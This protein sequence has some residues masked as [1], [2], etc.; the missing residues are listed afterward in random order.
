MPRQRESGRKCALTQ[1]HPQLLL[2]PSPEL[3]GPDSQEQ[4]RE[5]REAVVF[6]SLFDRPLSRTYLCGF[7]CMA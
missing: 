2:T 5:A 6:C 7:C 4:Q 3:E 1:P